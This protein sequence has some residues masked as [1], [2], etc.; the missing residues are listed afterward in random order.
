MSF[1]TQHSQDYAC[2]VSQTLNMMLGVETKPGIRINDT[3]NPSSKKS[4]HASIYFTGMVYGEY[5]LSMDE[6]TAN[7]LLGMPEESSDESRELLIDTFA[8]IANTVVGGTIVH[9]RDTYKKLTFSAPRIIF[10]QTVYPHINS[11]VSYVDTPHGKIECHFYL[12]TMRLE[13]ATSYEEV[14][15]TLVKS[16]KVLEK[17]NKKLKEQQGQLIHAE[18]MSSLG[19]MAAGVAHEIN[20]PLAFVISNFSTLE[21]YLETITQLFKIYQSLRESVDG[22][23]I[24]VSSDPKAESVKAHLVKISEINESDDLDFIIED[25]SSL[26]DDS[27]QG[28][29]RI[30]KIITG[31]KEF[32]HVD[33]AERKETDLNQLIDNAIALV[34]NQIKYKCDVQ[35]RYADIPYVNINS[36]EISQ[37]VANLLINASQAIDGFGKVVVRTQIHENCVVLSVTDSGKGIPEE[38]LKKIFNPFFTTKPVGEGT[39]LGLSISHNIINNHGGKLLVKSEEGKGTTFAIQLPIKGT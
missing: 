10:G 13:L 20:N 35:K 38:N 3:T 18:K 2:I 31:L 1:F 16:N 9:L 29:S 15:E 39:G 28:L 4:F 30:K 7:A 33:S 26:L 37:V 14:M 21:T 19:V 24:K 32:S 36:G 12:D 8:E 25:T 17:A 11:S 27:K 22:S 34:M 23:T 5:I 6:S